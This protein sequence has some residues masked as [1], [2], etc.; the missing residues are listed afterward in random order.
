M[1]KILDSLANGNFG[2]QCTKEKRTK[3]HQ[4]ACDTAY[5]LLDKLQKKLGETDNTLLNKTIDAIADV[6]NYSEINQFK[7]GFQLGA[8]LILEI[9]ASSE[10]VYERFTI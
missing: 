10:E 3:E 8:L 7:W 1:G 2:T 4:E 5:S 9:C 6:N